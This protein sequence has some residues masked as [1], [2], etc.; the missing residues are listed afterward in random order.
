MP[1]Q[2]WSTEL[3]NR[4]F[5]GPV[6][7]LLRILHIEPKYPQAPI[8]NAFAME[9]VVFLFLVVVFLL[10]RSRLSV[11][12]PGGLQ[13][14]TELF[15]GFVDTQ[16]HEIIGHGSERFVAFLT[17]LGVFILVCNL[18]GVIPT[19]ESPTGVPIVPLGCAICAFCYYNWQGIKHHGVANYFKHFFG[20]P[21]EGM[22]FVVRICLA[23]LMLPI[24][25]VSHFARLLS[26]TVRLWANIFAGDLVTLVFFSMIPIGIPVI[27]I[28]LHIG[29]AFLQA[30][31]FVLL[32]IIYLSGAVAEEH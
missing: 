17:T 9:L 28:G 30:Y 14:I 2:L 29:V 6:T 10:I 24:E 8:T 18:L 31:V 1:E 32:T 22:P 20:P 16:A 21:M 27:F 15:H 25:L 4:L 12:R 7:S 19:F 5:A 13:H 26:L 3:L 11:D 23:L